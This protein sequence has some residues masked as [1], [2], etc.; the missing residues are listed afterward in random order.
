MKTMSLESRKRMLST[1]ERPRKSITEQY[2]FCMECHRSDLSWRY[3][4]KETGLEDG[5]EWAENGGKKRRIY[6]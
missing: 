3:F 6:L 2:P 4:R 5:L 1:H